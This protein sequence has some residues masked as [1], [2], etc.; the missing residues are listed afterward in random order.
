MAEL[1]DID[2]LEDREALLVERRQEIADAA[3]DMR[4]FTLR[5]F[6]K[7]LPSWS[8]GLAGGAWSLGTGDPIGAAFAAAGLGAGLF[9]KSRTITAYSYLFNIQQR[10]RA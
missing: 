4:R 3:H 10:Y 2:V 8:L 5:T 7:N 9:G 1:A 6:R